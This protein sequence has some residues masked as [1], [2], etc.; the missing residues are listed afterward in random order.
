[1]ASRGSQLWNL[2]AGSDRGLQVKWYF[3][4]TQLRICER[5]ISGRSSSALAKSARRDGLEQ[6]NDP[7]YFPKFCAAKSLA[8][9]YQ[10]WGGG[11]GIED[12]CCRISR[13]GT[14]KNAVNF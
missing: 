7:A 12:Q 3:G 11:Q 9:T 13:F 4:F 1:M 6:A 8:E 5:L 14:M 10:W 2:V